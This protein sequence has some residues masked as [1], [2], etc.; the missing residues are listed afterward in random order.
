MVIELTHHRWNIH[1][2]RVNSLILVTFVIV[3]TVALHCTEPQLWSSEFYWF[4]LLPST[5]IHG[6][7]FLCSDWLVSVLNREL[8]TY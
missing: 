7:V 8:S 5:V 3:R 1:Y 2:M 6:Y 4:V